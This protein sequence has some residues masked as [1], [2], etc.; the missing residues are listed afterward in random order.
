MIHVPTDNNISADVIDK[1]DRAY[2]EDVRKNV[3]L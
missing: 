3:R 1:I 2:A